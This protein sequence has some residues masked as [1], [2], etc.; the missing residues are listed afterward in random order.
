MK[1][2][3]IL[4]AF[5]LATLTF[6]LP[7]MLSMS[8]A[9]L[10]FE[11]R[12]GKKIGAEVSIGTLELTWFGPQKFKKVELKNSEMTGS[13]ESIESHVPLWSLSQFGDA[14]SLQNGRL[15]FTRYNNLSIEEIEATIQGQD[16]S[17]EGIASQGGSFS[18]H[19]KIYS[20]TD[21]DLV[22]NFQAIPSPPLDFILKTKGFFSAAVGSTFDLSSTF[23]Y[24]RGE[25]K[26]RA[27]FSS[28][29]AKALLDGQI[30]QDALT[31]NQPLLLTL[32]FS[33]ELSRALGGR[34]LEAKNPITLQIETAG[35][36]IPLAP[37]ALDRLEI[38]KA[39]LTL[40]Q[41]IFTELHPLISLFALLN[42][43]PLTSSTGIIWFTPVA[44][45]I[46]K[47]LLH[48]GR[49]DALIANAVHLCGWGN[50]DL[51]NDELDMKLGIPADTLETSLGIKGLSRKYVLQIPVRGHLEDPKFETS[52]AAATIAALVAGKQLSNTLSK[53]TGVFGGLL[54]QIG[55]VG[56]VSDDPNVPPPNR[57]F[58]WE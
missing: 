54:N 33:P 9:K 16:I 58:P 11:A 57:P 19:G 53:K 1:K 28:P 47:G 5:I 26:L 51:S 14:F 30:S 7:Q 12:V 8:W 37:F 48:M 42:S 13:I 27:D 17:A 24:N 20:K 21:F 39:T 15:N 25:G 23:V 55:K 31:L 43:A 3:F 10:Q 2:I 35:A 40:G 29:N 6:F 49:V 46:A 50:A 44:F 4:L 41:L 52:G 18:V 45:S 38:G 32:L 34:I 36:S 56:Q 22:A